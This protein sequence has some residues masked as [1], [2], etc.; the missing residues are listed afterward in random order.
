VLLRI[1][2]ETAV[3]VDRERRE[4]G[5]GARL[6]LMAGGRSKSRR[7]R[8]RPRLAGLFQPIT[9]SILTMDGAFRPGVHLGIAIALLARAVL[10]YE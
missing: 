6:F 7:V 2:V 8:L 3:V 4:R 5:R 9:A 1:E 10:V